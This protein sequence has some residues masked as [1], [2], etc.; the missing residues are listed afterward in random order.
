M[1]PFRGLVA[2]RLIERVVNGGREVMWEE[3]VSWLLV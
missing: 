2:M 3:G 1:S